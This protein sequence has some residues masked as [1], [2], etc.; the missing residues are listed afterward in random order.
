MFVFIIH[1]IFYSY[2]YFFTSVFLSVLKI[3]LY[4]LGCLLLVLLNYRV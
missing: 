4:E 1:L 2:T 3:F